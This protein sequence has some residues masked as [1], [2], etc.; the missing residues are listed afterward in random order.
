M[1]LSRMELGAWHT[2]LTLGVS[3]V[4]EHNMG[5]H[6]YSGTSPQQTHFYVPF[7]SNSS[8]SSNSFIKS[9]SSQ[10]R[11]VGGPPSSS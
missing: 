9:H 5:S 1:I 2:W 8:S 4:P 3:N 6:Q 11:R 10:G 7:S